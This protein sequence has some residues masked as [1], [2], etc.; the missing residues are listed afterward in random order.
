[1]ELHQ[2]RTERELKGAK[3]EKQMIFGVVLA[4]MS[5]ILFM[6]AADDLERR[7]GYMFMSIGL[8][9]IALAIGTG[10]VV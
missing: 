1:M 10:N 6:F 2:V 8:F 5:G 3:G 4:F 7:F 9:V